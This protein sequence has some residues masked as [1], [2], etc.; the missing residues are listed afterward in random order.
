MF[1]YARSDTHFLLYVYDSM[2]NELVEGSDF[3][4]AE[5]NLVGNVLALS[6][7]TALQRFEHPFYDETGLGAY[8]WY[9]LLARTP[10]LFSKEQFAVFRAVHQWRDAVARHEDDSINY[11]M[12]NHAVFA[13]A[14]EMPAEKPALFSVVVPMSQPVRLRVDELVAVIS[15]ARS[16]GANGPDMSSVMTKLS[17]RV[18]Q[19]KYGSRSAPEDR[20]KVSSSDQVPP[21]EASISNLVART[22]KQLTTSRLWGSIFGRSYSTQAQSMATGS[23]VQLQLPLPDITAEVFEAKD[24]NE[25]RPAPLPD[26][27]YVRAADR[28]VSNGID[29][30]FVVKQLGGNKRKRLAELPEQADTVDDEAQRLEEE[31]R[32]RKAEKKAA[33]KAAKQQQQQQQQQQA[34]D[35]VEG[36]MANDVEPFDYANAPSVL[37]ATRQDTRKRQDGRKRPDGVFDVYARAADAPKGLGRTQKE[38]PGKSAT[39][40]K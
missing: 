21:S 7:T 13:L 31:K 28:S 24:T 9:R 27:E 25:A 6:K 35:V 32:Q 37:N 3:Q 16:A 33:K 10:A 14:R 30:V 12:S 38:R 8:G 34:E 23:D 17:E 39:F 40:K 2:R 26:H 11:I 5:Q 19:S 22:A 18:Y 4:D 1:D 15:K 20:T 36:D 29:D